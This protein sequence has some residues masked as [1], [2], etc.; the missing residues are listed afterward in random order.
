MEGFQGMR[1]LL[2]EDD[3]SLRDNLGRSLEADG[4]ESEA[5]ATA[6]EAIKKISERHFDLVVTDYNLGSGETGLVLLGRLREEGYS[7]S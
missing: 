7:L 5:A 2:V 3:A 6:E 1:V 4:W